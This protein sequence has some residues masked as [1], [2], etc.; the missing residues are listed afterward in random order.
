[1][2]Q[3]VI[4]HIPHFAKAL[5]RNVPYQYVLLEKRSADM[6]FRNEKKFWYGISAYSGPFQALD[7]TQFM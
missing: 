1:M 6:K 2:V 5:L 4:F 3:D 7:P